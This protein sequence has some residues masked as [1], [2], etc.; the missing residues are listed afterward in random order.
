M[1]S[2]SIT[3]TSSAFQPN[4]AIPAKYTC[5]GGDVSP[6]LGTKNRRVPDILG[7]YALDLGNGYL[8]HGT[9]FKETI[10]AAAT[11]GCI[12][13]RDEDIQWLYDFVPVGTKVYIY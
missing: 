8:L 11:H 10:G 13:L 6:P 4:G 3:L 1:S 5:E 12:R 7:A 2:R 9:P